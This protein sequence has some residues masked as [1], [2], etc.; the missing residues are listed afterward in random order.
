VDPIQ[1]IPAANDPHYDLEVLC[2]GWN[3]LVVA[4]TEPMEAARG[5]IAEV[6][7]ADVEAFLI[8][9]YRFQRG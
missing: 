9:F 2:A 8:R 1:Y 5:F 6:A 4:I 3:P 7:G